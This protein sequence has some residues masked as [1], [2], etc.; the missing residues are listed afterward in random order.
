MAGG[1][2]LAWIILTWI[3]WKLADY[4]N[5]FTEEHNAANDDILD[6]LIRRKTYTEALGSDVHNL[7]MMFSLS[8]G[9]N[10]I[11]GQMNVRTSDRRY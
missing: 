5:R 11:Q 4:G 7:C 1:S 3:Q 2:V 10:L 8:Y 9:R 6:N